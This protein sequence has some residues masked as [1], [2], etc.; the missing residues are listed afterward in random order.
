LKKR[1]EQEGTGKFEKKKISTGTVY[2]KKPE[3]E[4]VEENITLSSEELARIEELS[5]QF[6]SKE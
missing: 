4:K 1:K 6:D 2:T 3:K 5:K